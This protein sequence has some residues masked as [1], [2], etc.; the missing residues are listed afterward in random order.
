MKFERTDVGHLQ[1]AGTL[2]HLDALEI[3][4]EMFLREKVS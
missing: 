1:E 4:Y 2:P 3:R